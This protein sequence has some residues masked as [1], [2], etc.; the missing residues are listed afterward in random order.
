MWVSKTYVKRMMYNFKNTLG[1]YPPKQHGI[2]HPN[3]KPDIDT[4]DLFNN[5]EKYQYWK[6]IGDMQWAV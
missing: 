3:Y 5:H 6:C 1:F 2:M 4:T